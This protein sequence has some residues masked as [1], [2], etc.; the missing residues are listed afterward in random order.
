[1]AIAEVKVW[2][3]GTDE[4]SVSSFIRDCFRLAED[5]EEIEA[6]LTPTSTILEGP[7]STVMTVA[8]QMHHAPFGKGCNRVITTITIDER[9]DHDAHMEDMIDSVITDI[10]S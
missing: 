1:M 5:N 3:V 7:L 9:H 8:R 6:V 10:E 4:A 2:P